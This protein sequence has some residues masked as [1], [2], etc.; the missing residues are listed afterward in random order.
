MNSSIS[1]LYVEDKLDSRMVM[2]VMLRRRMGL[3]HVTI[4]PD[5]ADFV[6]RLEAL[7]PTPS[8]IFLDIHVPPIDGFAMLAAIRTNPRFA[9]VPVIALTASVMNEEVE[10]LRLSGF[11]GC[12]GKPIDQDTF[13]T[14]VDRLLNGESIWNV[15]SI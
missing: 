13:P 15:I 9:S 10:Q 14:L 2:D 1:I 4:W 11:N 5:S 6:P 7:Q 8:L 3:E 12:L